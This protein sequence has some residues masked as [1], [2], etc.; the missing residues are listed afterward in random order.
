MDIL[1]ENVNVLSPDSPE[2]LV[3]QNVAIAG[4]HIAAITADPIAPGPAT[5]RISG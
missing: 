2:M 3:G 1:I 4:N 5:K